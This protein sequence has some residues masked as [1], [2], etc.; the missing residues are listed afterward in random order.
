MLTLLLLA[1]FAAVQRGKQ[2]LALTA[3]K[4]CM[5]EEQHYWAKFDSIGFVGEGLETLMWLTTVAF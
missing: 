5:Q 1:N 3:G 4:Y 2:L